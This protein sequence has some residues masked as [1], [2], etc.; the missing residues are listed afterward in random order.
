MRSI[1]GNCWYNIFVL[2]CYHSLLRCFNWTLWNLSERDSQRHTGV[3]TVLQFLYCVGSPWLHCQFSFHSDHS[4]T[5]WEIT[6]SVR[7]TNAGAYVVVKSGKETLLSSKAVH[8]PTLSELRKRTIY[9]M[10][11]WHILRDI[12][13]DKR[14]RKIWTATVRFKDVCKHDKAILLID[15][16]TW[17]VTL[18]GHGA[19]QRCVQAR[20]DDDMDRHHNMI[21]NFFWRKTWI[22]TVRNHREVC[23]ISTPRGGQRAAHKNIRPRFFL[24]FCFRRAWLHCTFWLHGEPIKST[25][26]NN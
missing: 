14:K 12:D 26:R 19:I 2:C 21:G 4:G 8:P 22:R 3:I 24:P 13:C 20:Q 9:R 10:P 1:L 18:G 15:I 6:S 17:E 11:Y 23:A 5:S 25:M 7:T 16:I